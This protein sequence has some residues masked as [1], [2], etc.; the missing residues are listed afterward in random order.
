M[1]LSASM[2]ASAGSA[3]SEVNHDLRVGESILLP[4]KGQ[5]RKAWTNER[6][7]EGNGPSGGGK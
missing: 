3:S 2:A 1:H 5:I 6:Y 7:S 4:P